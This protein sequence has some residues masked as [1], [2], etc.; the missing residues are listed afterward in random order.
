MGSVKTERDALF[1]A[2]GNLG[3]QQGKNEPLG[4]LQ[5]GVGVLFVDEPL[6]VGSND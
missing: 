5:S 3:L 4:A 2:L 6:L 1:Q